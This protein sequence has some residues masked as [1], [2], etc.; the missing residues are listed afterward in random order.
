MKAKDK[1]P[2]DDNRCR[3]SKIHVG[4]VAKWRFDNKLLRSL[5]RQLDFIG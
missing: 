5:H 1:G 4:S 2:A 3:L